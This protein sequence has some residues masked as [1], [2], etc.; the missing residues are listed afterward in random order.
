MRAREAAA[1][2]L[3]GWVGVGA[4]RVAA[5][6]GVAC[7]RVDVMVAEERMFVGAECGMVVVQLPAAW[8]PARRRPDQRGPCPKPQA[9]TLSLS[10]SLLALHCDLA[11]FASCARL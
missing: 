3:G 4:F 6:R 5:T 9:S 10:P 2:V 7:S 1:V 8:R 11:R